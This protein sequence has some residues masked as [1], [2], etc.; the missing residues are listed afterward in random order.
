M[1][2]KS[3]L[4]KMTIREQAS[5]LGGSDWW[6]T[7]P[8]DKYGIPSVMVS[9]GPTGLRKEKMLGVSITATCYPTAAA[10]A[11][12]WDV[13][14]VGKMG[15]T[16][17]DECLANRLS[18]LLG[19][20]I[21]IK[22]SPLCGR[23]F[24]YYSEDPVLAGE[25]AASYID[26]VQSRGVGTSL[27]HF[28]ANSTETR[29]MLAD[30]IVDERSLR[31]IYLRGFEIAVKKSQPWTIMAAY[32]KING[33]YCT[34]S[35][36]LLTE[37]L[38][39]DWGFKGLVVSDWNSV[40][41]RIAGLK[42]GM[43]L[44]MPTARYYAI[45]QI[46][47]A[48]RENKITLDDIQTSASRVLDLV[49]KSLPQLMK[50]A[51]EIDLDEHHKIAREI[52]AGCPVLLKN[53]GKTLPLSSKDN[54]LVI[55]ARAR[56]PL[57]Q[58]GGSSMVNSYMV[59]VPYIKLS[60][61][62]RDISYAPG[63]DLKNDAASPDQGLI[64]EAVAKAKNADKVV[65]F[66]SGKMEDVCEGVDRAD[67]KI[68]AGMNA[69]VDEVCKVND[70]VAVVISSGCSVE[71]PWAEKPDSIIQTYLLGEAFGGA[72]ADILMGR[73][74]PSGKLAESYP[75][76]LE[77][78]PCLEE[79]QPDKNSNVKYKEGIFVGYRYYEKQGIKVRYPFG[80]GL[81]Y[82]TFDYSN[83]SVSSKDYKADDDS[84][85]TLKFDITNT[86]NYDGAEV[87]QI[88]VSAPNDSFVARPEKELKA[89]RKVFLKV[90]ETKTVEVELD[91][92]A[93]EYY[94][95]E[96]NGWKVEKGNYNVMVGASSADI[97][98]AE[99][100]AVDSEDD[101]SW[102]IDY[103]AATPNYYKGDIK[104]V[105]TDEFYDN[106]GYDLDKFLPDPDDDRLTALNCFADAT[107]S[108]A[109]KA[110]NKFF[111]VLFDKLPI[112]NAASLVAHDSVVYLPVN[113]LMK[114]TGGIL[115]DNVGDA[116]VHLLN[117]GKGVDALKLAAMGIPE[118]VK[119]F[120]MP[121]IL[122]KVSKKDEMK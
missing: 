9:D 73:V 85:L 70:K 63:Y 103:R 36:Y 28:A 38:R 86:G 94:S 95:T 33:T 34:E 47:K 6:H 52:A 25:L 16:L 22:R 56:K 54:V 48:Y 116:I 53:G 13:D 72:I 62:I 97:R 57:Y 23:N 40:S 7:V 15:E 8:L 91:R 107:D 20:G 61:D 43:D 44:Q 71:V 5:L 77:D 120:A 109:G 32:N 55:G 93:F 113:R 119:N 114:M 10:V 98:M 65:I 117:G 100:I 83:F 118:G 27:K 31:E 12:S 76:A 29:R 90:G 19:P 92:H 112:G 39:N 81:S 59:D 78:A 111:D 101:L 18:V 50:P 88:Y 1:D 108:K 2:Y 121:I 17:G 30:S 89:F 58:G 105:D 46:A 41:D 99:T 64:K 37:V 68:P 4:K 11:S 42:A 79:Y 75:M 35:S 14:L 87:A 102:E 80:Y 3:W 122:K 51:P 66:V 45:S 82:T 21:N 67:M 84:K 49:Q 69:L 26:G 115:S 96:L 104:A 110:I 106:L 24:E 60:N 74:S